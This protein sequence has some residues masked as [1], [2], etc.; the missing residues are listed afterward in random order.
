MRKLTAIVAAVAMIA[1]MT[2]IQVAAATPA[3]TGGIRG[4]VIENT[5]RT[6]GAG[7][8]A[9]LVNSAGNPVAGASVAVSNDGAYFINNVA[10]GIYTLRIVGA[11]GM[12]AVAVTAGKVSVA[13]LTVAPRGVAAPPRALSTAAKWWIAAAAIGGGITTWAIVAN[14]NDASGSK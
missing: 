3:T 9:E 2:P 5:G 14:N 1:A 12:T 13:N 10:P 8:R 7:L 4:I 6:V 11:Q